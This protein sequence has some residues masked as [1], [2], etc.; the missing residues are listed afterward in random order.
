[1]GSSQ[2]KVVV[3][4]P[5]LEGERGERGSVGKLKVGKVPVHQLTVYGRHVDI[6][7]RGKG[8][9][10]EERRREGRRRG[11]EERRGGGGEEGR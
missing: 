2:L 11:G 8:R 6:A 10:G 9:G 3:L 1:M 5:V 4:V 7:G